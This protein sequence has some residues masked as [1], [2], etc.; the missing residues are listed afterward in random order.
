[1]PV[2]LL[3]DRVMKWPDAETVRAAAARWAASVG[4]TRGEVCAIGIFGSYARGDWGVGSDLDAV[5][6]VDEIDAP[7][8]RRA[9]AFDLPDLPVP[10]DL[11]VYSASEWEQ[12]HAGGMG[13]AA[14]EMVWLY[15]R[16]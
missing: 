7:Y 15:R 13:R 8:E 12:L 9:L 11:L 10:V 6:I 1:M 16:A 14:D 5:I 3:T 2:R 4:S